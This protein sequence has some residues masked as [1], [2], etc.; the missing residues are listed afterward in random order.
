[1]PCRVGICCLDV[2]G[3]TNLEQKINL[4]T[5]TITK[6]KIHPAKGWFFTLVMV[7]VY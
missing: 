2:F 4:I 3:G 1:M 6:V 5:D 7:S